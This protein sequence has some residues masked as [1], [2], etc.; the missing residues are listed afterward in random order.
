M[1]KLAVISGFT[2]MTGS[3]LGKQLLKD[4]Y[5]IVAFDNFFAS[6]IESIKDIKSNKNLYFFEYDINS[7]KDMSLLKEFI[8]N[9]FES[10]EIEF[11]NCAAVVHTKHFY[12]VDD[13]FT[14]NVLGMKSF[15]DMAISLNAKSYINCSTSE[16]YSMESWSEDGMKEEDAVVLATAENS[17][18]TSYATGK[19]LTE[20]FL[21]DAV[22][23]NKIKGCSLRFANVYSSDELYPDHIIP[24]IISSLQKS[25]KITLLN[26]SKVNKR[27]FLHNI[28]SCS[29]ILCLLKEY[30][31]LDGSVYNV[32]TKEEIS[33]IDLV[34]KIAHK[35]NIK[36][37]EINYEGFREND[38]I[39]RLINCDK[40]KKRTSWMD[41]I[42]LDEGLD[43][44]LK[45]KNKNE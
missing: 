30:E 25:N 13:T 37:L 18:R 45:I 40:I 44:S 6:S 36:D 12:E 24:H 35:M 28:D 15:L 9:K 33:M 27:T 3:E 31:A 14:T 23:K 2:G 43:I 38:P 4:D 20:F 16:V 11:I 17:Q 19:L 42:S 41:T 7:L 32:G 10:F 39:R 1:N 29:S 22:I 26:N 5:K 8:N 34:K 21:R